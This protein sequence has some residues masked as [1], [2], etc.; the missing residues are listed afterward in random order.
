MFD[1]TRFTREQLDKEYNLRARTPDF[2][3]FLDRYAAHSTEAR[4]TLKCT[5][6]IAYGKAAG[7][8]LDVFHAQRPGSPV[9]VFIHGGYW[10]LLDKSDHSFPALGF[11]PA[12]CAV[13]SINYTL[14]PAA[15][16]D[17]IVRQAQAAVAWVC[18]HAAEFGGDPGR[19]YVT[20]HSAGGH[21]AAMIPPAPTLQARIA[22]RGGIRGIA[23]ISGLFDLEPLRHTY[24]QPVLQ[25]SEE[26]ARRNSP[27]HNIPTCGMSLLAAAGSLEPLPFTQ[28]TQDYASTWNKKGNSGEA[29]ILPKEHHFSVVL[30]LADADSTLA[31][32][33]LH[34]MGL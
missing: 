19:I 14:A 30:Q 11:V 33:M 29:V 32:A 2:Q 4:R 10:Q 20:G 28:G 6:D 7:E 25:L 26:V 17:E 24:Q 23:P 21:L 3:D 15:P 8:R 16:M 1:H 9:L 31:K 34:Q 22:P 5:L 13:V 27:M 12:G 18:A